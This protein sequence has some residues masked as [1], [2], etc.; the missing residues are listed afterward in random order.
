MIKTDCPNLHKPTS[1]AVV[2][3]HHSYTFCGYLN[4]L[5]ELLQASYTFYD[6][7]NGYSEILKASYK[8]PSEAWYA[9]SV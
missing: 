8:P 2:K 1:F 9:R 6:G 3:S 5:T 4:A 7:K